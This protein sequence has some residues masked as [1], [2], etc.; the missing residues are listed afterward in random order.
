MSVAD[1]KGVTAFIKRL[2]MDKNFNGQRVLG[3][4]VAAGLPA[5]ARARYVSGRARYVSGRARYVSGRARYVS[6]RARYVSGRAR[7][8]SGRARYVSGR[9]QSLCQWTGTLCQSCL[10]T[11]SVHTELDVSGLAG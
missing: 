7:Y 1:M 4:R 8:V 10:S 6:G 3:D 5:R 9:A 11:K 2:L